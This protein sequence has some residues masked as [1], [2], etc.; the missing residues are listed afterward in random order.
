MMTLVIGKKKKKRRRRRRRNRR[1]G[2]RKA[3]LAAVKLCNIHLIYIIMYL[4]SF[5]SW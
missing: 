5:L 4:N 3:P 2:E 1:R